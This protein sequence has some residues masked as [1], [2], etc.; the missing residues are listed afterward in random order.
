M[1]QRNTRNRILPAFPTRGPL[2]PL[3]RL[4]HHAEQVQYQHNEQD[5]SEDS[6]AAACSPPG[7]SVIA[8]TAA[9]Q[10]NQNND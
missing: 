10:Q 4:T 5:R 8:A 2:T 7:I 6:K 1:H 3:E 9:E